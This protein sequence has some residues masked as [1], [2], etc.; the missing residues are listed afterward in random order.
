MSPC[1]STIRAGSV[2]SQKESLLPTY[3]LTRILVFF[4]LFFCS[5]SVHKQLGLLG[6]GHSCVTS[7]VSDLITCDPLSLICLVVY[8]PHRPQDRKLHSVNSTVIWLLWKLCSVTKALDLFLKS[9]HWDRR[10]T[11]LFVSNQ[12]CVFRHHLSAFVAAVT[13]KLT[14]ITYS[15]NMAFQHGNL[16]K[17][18]VDNLFQS[19]HGLLFC[20]HPYH[21]LLAAWIL[22]VWCNCIT[23]DSTGSPPKLCILAHEMGT[24]I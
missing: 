14:V 8:K 16:L 3:P 18:T 12:I 15:G 24:H 17:I 10:Y 7:H 13:T 22:L 23:L 1:S 4:S 2:T 9:D 11:Q 21:L 6:P 19:V 5:K 20:Y